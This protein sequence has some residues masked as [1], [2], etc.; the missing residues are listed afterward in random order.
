MDA[1]GQLNSTDVRRRWLSTRQT[2]GSKH[3]KLGSQTRIHCE[4]RAVTRRPGVVDSSHGS[5]F[6]RCGSALLW[7]LA[8][9]LHGSMPSR[10]SFRRDSEICA[11]PGCKACCVFRR[12]RGS[13]WLQ[14][15]RSIRGDVVQSCN[16]AIT[17]EHRSGVLSEQI[18]LQLANGYWRYH[19]FLP[20]M[21]Q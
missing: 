5:Q 1:W 20:L 21:A 10:S 12:S 13:E 16:G 2:S 17:R 4:W 14:G 7:V 15:G 9:P 19:R 18:R 3:E 11:C 8:A 6:R